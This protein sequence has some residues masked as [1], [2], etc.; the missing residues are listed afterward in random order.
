MNDNKKINHI[1]GDT[2]APIF[3]VSNTDSSLDSNPNTILFTKT[4]RRINQDTSNILPYDSR[5]NTVRAIVFGHSL[6]RQDYDYFSYIFTL[7]K[8]NTLDTNKMGIIEF[9]FYVYDD[10]RRAEI[11]GNLSK[12][13]Q[14][15]IEY[16]EKNV[17]GRDSLVLTNLLRF[18]GKLR[19][20]EVKI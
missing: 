7:L 9:K 5:E 10:S 16:Y 20:S 12:S 11:C 13:I 15:L 8:F 14:N 6:N 4:Q 2:L 19:I 18:S 3:G 1:N 17:C